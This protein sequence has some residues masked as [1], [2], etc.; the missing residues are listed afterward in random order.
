MIGKRSKDGGGGK[1]GEW[2]CRWWGGVII[3]GWRGSEGTKEGAGEQQDSVIE[4]G[5]FGTE[6][7]EVAD[8]IKQNV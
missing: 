4:I 1:Y 6:S 3:R 8:G 7:S 2:G 5:V